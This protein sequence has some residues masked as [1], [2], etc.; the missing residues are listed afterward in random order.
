[1]VASKK[2]I[3]KKYIK[4]YVYN[5]LWM[6]NKE[7][8]QY[9][10]RKNKIEYKS[11]ETKNILID[12]LKSN[13]KINFW[14]IY[15]EYQ[16]TFSI[17]LW[18]LQ[19]LLGIDNKMR[20]KLTEKGFL[21]VNRWEEKKATFGKYDAPFY[22]LETLY[23]M[24]IS[25]LEELKEKFKPK[26]R[27]QK[28][29]EGAVRAAE[30][31]ARKKEEEYKRKLEKVTK[32]T[33]CVICKEPTMDYNLINWE[34]ICTSCCRE[35]Q[36]EKDR[37]S[38]ILKGKE[39]M[40][41]KDNIA[42]LDMET[43]NLEFND[44]CS[45]SVIDTDYNILIDTLVKPI[46]NIDMGATYAHG[47]SNNDVINSPTIKELLPK[48][49]EIFNKYNKIYYYNIGY[50]S[51]KRCLKKVCIQIDEFVDRDKFECLESIIEAFGGDADSEYSHAVGKY[52]SSIP[53]NKKIDIDTAEYKELKLRNRSLKDC[54]CIM[55]FLKIADESEI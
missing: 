13:K 49:M 22:D 12:R 24:D 21:K 14:E 41:N 47:I 42:I 16:I 25:M 5:N 26:K 23:K 29:I 6:L 40:K 45:I 15:K 52:V 33:T 10:L 8:I 3:N 46:G 28:Q 36:Q 7:D 54:C 31:R 53:F 9:L 39:I 55:N 44:I 43:T 51:L 20:K 11:K 19:E 17:S 38:A 48:L 37:E 34:G 18:D 35:I 32:D 30:T 1:M 50:Y 27:T 4:D 2:V